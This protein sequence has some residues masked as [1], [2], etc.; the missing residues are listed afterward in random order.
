M[1]I[2]GT[3]TDHRTETGPTR[4]AFLAAAA[5]ALAIAARPCAS[6]EPR[7]F[8]IGR[9]RGRWFF[10]TPEGRPFFSVA[11]NHIDPSPLEG[12]EGQDRWRDKY[13]NSMQRW[14]RE[15]VAVD[16]ADWGFNSVGWVQEWVTSA[17]RHSRSFTFEEY[18]CLGLPYCHRL[19]FAE[20][21]QWDGWS[22]H[23]DLKGSDFEDW[24][25]HV[26]RSD[27]RRMADDPRLIGYFYVDCPTWTH[28]RPAN[29]WKGPLFDPERLTSAA[30]R[31]ELRDLAGHYYRV[32]HDAIRRHD[33]N[34]LILGDRYEAN[35]PLAD[36]VVEAALPYVDL[37]SFQDFKPPGQVEA[38]L[39]RFHQR[40]GK[41]VLLAD[42]CV[43]RTLADGSK[44]HVPDGYRRLLEAARGV[45]GCVGLHLCGA[46]LKNQRR[47]RG[48][49]NADESPDVEAIAA[50]R[51]ANRDAARW[52]ATFEDPS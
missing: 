51:E 30:G 22:R 42:S 6:G 10:L 29:A 40:F 50:I 44:Q 47:R 11:L 14:L 32:T 16:L 1:P 36:E 12:P 46:Y 13:G 8:R 43:A 19:P 2:P 25:D 37:L 28:V 21:H 24:C 34:H 45:E 52:M 20:F 23:P 41:P 3:R 15:S 33:R 26:A 35:A 48:L 9:R 7:F 49:R 5:S 18:Q 27:C 39:A 38:D 31:R 17:M 4:R